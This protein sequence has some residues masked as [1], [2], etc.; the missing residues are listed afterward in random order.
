MRLGGP[1]LRHNLDPGSWIAELKRWGYSAAVFPLDH[2]APPEVVRGFVDSAQAADIVI[3]E[4]GAWS[5]PLSRDEDQRRKAIALCQNQLALADSMGARC[6]V[7]IAGSRGEVWDGPHPDNLT[8]D[9]FDLVVETTRTIIDAVRPTRTFFTLEAMPWM[10]PDSPDSYLRLIHAID[11]ERFAVHLDP[12][13]LVHSPQLYFRNGDL[14]REC[15]QKLGPYI[16]NC[17]AKDI[18]LANTLT[19]HL[20]EVR[21]G[22]GALDYSTFLRELSRLGPDT[23]LILEHLNAAEEYRAAAEYVRAVAQREGITLTRQGCRPAAGSPDKED[24]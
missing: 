1:V 5:N 4:I 20:D 18:A 6:C 17:H 22:L 7:N 12:V 16:K 11:R 2:T 10:Y 9:T 3:A 8:P 14:I 13:N 15:F 24:L 23:S 21:P 19:V